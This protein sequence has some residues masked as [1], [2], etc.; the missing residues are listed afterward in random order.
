MIRL[1]SRGKSSQMIKQLLKCV[2]TWLKE[3]YIALDTAPFCWL[4]IAVVFHVAT[5]YKIDRKDTNYI[6]KE[7]KECKMK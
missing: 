6:I 3:K 4:N 7:L 1:I 5:A 2:K